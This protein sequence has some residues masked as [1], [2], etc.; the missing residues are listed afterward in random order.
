MSDG[1][2]YELNATTSGSTDGVIERWEQEP[3]VREWKRKADALDELIVNVKHLMYGTRE[4][5]DEAVYRLERQFEALEV[6]DE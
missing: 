5:Q 6:G 2:D 3:T 1:E 4:Q